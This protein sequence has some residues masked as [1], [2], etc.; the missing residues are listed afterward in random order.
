MRITVRWV[1]GQVERLNR[2][3]GFDKVEYNTIGAIRLSSENGH[4][5]L[6]QVANEYGGCHRLFTGTTRECSQF[7]DG[8][9]TGLDL[10]AGI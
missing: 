7:I 3:L 8:M 9:N 4:M 5:V 1:D 6:R 2:K 10:K